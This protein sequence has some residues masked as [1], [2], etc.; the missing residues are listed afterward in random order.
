VR[1]ND[2]CPTCG[3]PFR[4]GHVY[5]NVVLFLGQP[6][7]FCSDVCEASWIAGHPLVATLCDW[8]RP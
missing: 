7:G 1:A 5:D 2:T 6:I 4:D 8:R 3:D